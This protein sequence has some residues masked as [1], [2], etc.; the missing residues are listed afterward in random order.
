MAFVSPFLSKAG[1]V[2]RLKNVGSTLKAA[3]TGKTVYAFTPSAK[4]DKVLSAA[5]SNP[6]TT[7]AIGA[8]AVGPGTAASAAGSAFKALPTVGKVAVVGAAPVAAGFV[9][10]NPGSVG[11]AA[12]LPA[13]LTELGSDLGR[14]VQN[15]TLETAKETFQNSP[16]ILSALGIAGAATVGRGAANT[17]ATI[18]NTRAIRESTEAEI[19]TSLAGV[20]ALS[21]PVSAL[22]A[23]PASEP[24]TN[25]TQVIGKE[26]KSV[27]GSRRRTNRTIQVPVIN[28]RVHVE[29]LN[30]KTYIRRR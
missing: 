5:A 29:V 14:L 25:A 22:Q 18:Q 28:N 10:Q 23:T 30:R 6:F 8:V 1:Q 21:T 11:T 16:V 27:S 13:E 26:A 4:A 24:V 7:A 3:L 9:I 2:E 20:P 15:P 17:I 19:P 12:K